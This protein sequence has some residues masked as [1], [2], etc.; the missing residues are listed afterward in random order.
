MAYSY[1]L[2]KY[3]YFC[4]VLIEL[5]HLSDLASLSVI[6]F[7]SWKFLE[8]THTWSSRVPTDVILTGACG[9]QLM[10]FELGNQLL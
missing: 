8:D 10:S 6:F 5:L 2:D 1:T 9:S 4:Y 7:V 3:P